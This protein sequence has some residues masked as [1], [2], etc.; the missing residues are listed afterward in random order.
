MKKGEKT[1][2]MLQ[3]DLWWSVEVCELVGIYLLGKVSNIIGKEKTGL[4]R[5]DQ[6]TVIENANRL[7][8]DHLRKY[9]IAIFHNKGLKIT[10]DT[11]LTTTDFLDVTSDL[12]TG[13]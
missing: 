9:L 8:L 2:L 13:K 11:N 1:Y 3:W 10:I 4:Y 12:C 7:K 6:L 5:D